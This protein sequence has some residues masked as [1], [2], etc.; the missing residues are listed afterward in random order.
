MC[1]KARLSHGHWTKRLQNGV[2]FVRGRP[3]EHVPACARAASANDLD[4]Q[5]FQATSK[6]DRET[7]RLRITSHLCRS[8]TSHRRKE[9][10]KRTIFER[11]SGIRCGCNQCFHAAERRFSVDTFEHFARYA[12][13]VRIH[14]EQAFFECGEERP[15]DGDARHV[16]PAGFG[17][18][19]V[20]NATARGEDL[21]LRTTH[22]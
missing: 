8:T 13:H 6:L 22:E 12:T 11:S 2:V 4:V 15:I 9:S 19:Q 1:R 21:I 10:R 17:K 3:D 7:I 16:R 20:E 5:V 18:R 14:E